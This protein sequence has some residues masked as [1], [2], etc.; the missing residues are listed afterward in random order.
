MTY[1]HGIGDSSE[2]DGLIDWE[3]ARLMGCEFGLTRAASTGRWATVAGVYKPL[4]TIDAAFNANAEGMYKAGV[5]RASY[6]W[7]DPRV[8]YNG[9][10]A[11]AENYLTAINKDPGE[12]GAAIDLENAG[13]ITGYI[14]VG[15][16][17]HKWLL[18]VGRE[19]G[20]RPRIYSNA[21]FIKTYLWNATI[22]ETWLL[23]YELLVAHWG[24][25]APIVPPPY[26]P[27]GWRAWQYTNAGIGKPYGF[28]KRPVCLMVWRSE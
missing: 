24:A 6:A 23:D 5:K 12:F 3:A 15:A 7:F 4:M 16:E 10:E 8:K 25:T 14:G 27:N 1:I 17:I 21:N 11:Q 22:Q 26:Y 13:T 20:Q 9:A 2:N 18:Y 28:G 19:L